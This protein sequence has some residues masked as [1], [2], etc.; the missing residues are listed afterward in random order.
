[1]IYDCFPFF[2]ELELL[3]IRLNELD[4][5]VDKVVLVECTKTHQNKDKPL[6]FNENKHLFSNF[7]HKIIHIIVDD[8]PV[9]DPWPI[10]NYQR[11]QIAIGLKDCAPEDMIIISDADE[12]VSP[13][14][15]THYR[16]NLEKQ[17]LYQPVQDLYYYYFN[18]FVGSNWCRAKLLTYD[19]FNKFSDATT[20]RLADGINLFNGG[21]HFGYLGGVDRVVQ[22]LESFAHTEFNT[23]EYKDRKMLE[24]FIDAGRGIIY[25]QPYFNFVELDARFPTYILNNTEKFKHLIKA[26]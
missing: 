19:L 8:L 9:S 11:N 5:V 6:Y 13:A 25:S 22:K 16:D 21:W 1:M 2:N 7:E 20:V 14:T 3:E 23:P 4:H 10:E 12:L 15:I 26:T 17:H 18:C 24:E